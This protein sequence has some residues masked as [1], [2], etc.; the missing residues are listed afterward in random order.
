[1]KREHRITADGSSTLYVPH[2]D[3][4]YHSTHGA[5][6]ESRHVFIEA[7]LNAAKGDPVHVLEIGFGTGLNALLTLAAA[8]RNR[9]RTVYVSLEAYPLVKEEWEQLD[10]SQLPEVRESQKRL[11]ELHLAPW[12]QAVQIGD[13]FLLTKRRLK[14]EDWESPPAF[15]VVYFDAFAPEAQPE[16][17]TEDVFRRM[18]DSLLPGGVL[19]TYSAK[20]EVRRR[21]SAVGFRVEKLPGPPGKRE[22]LRAWKDQ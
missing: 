14:L 13:A 15:H 20:G 7:G 11:A 9:Q 10:Y 5:A 18:Y 22:M 6:Q 16:L 21:L 12:E 1:M 4:H 17:W 3:Q 8:E 19:V 2:W